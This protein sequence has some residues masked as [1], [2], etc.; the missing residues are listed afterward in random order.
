MGRQERERQK[1][2]ERVRTSSLLD[3]LPASLQVYKFTI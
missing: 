1:E 3:D 2:G